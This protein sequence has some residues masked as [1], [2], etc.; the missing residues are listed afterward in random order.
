MPK[1]VKINHLVKTQLA[2]I[3]LLDTQF[4]IWG[5][6]KQDLSEIVATGYEKTMLFDEHTF[7]LAMSHGSSGIWAYDKDFARCSCDKSRAARS[8]E[9]LHELYSCAGQCLF[10]SLQQSVEY[11]L[12]GMDRRL[13]EYQILPL[14]C[15]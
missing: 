10:Q 3:E 12:Y 13:L 2:G 4:E 1:E 6:P 11:E 5:G 15:G 7:G 8:L 14:V 9:V